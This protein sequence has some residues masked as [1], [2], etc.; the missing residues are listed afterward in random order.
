[1]HFIGID[2]SLTGSGVCVVDAGGQIL[3][4]HYIQPKNSRGVRRLDEITRRILDIA[5]QYDG[6]L[7]TVREEYSYGSKGRATFSLGELGGTIDLSLLRAA[8]G[9]ALDF[10]TAVAGDDK[11]AFHAHFKI[12]PTTHKKL[13]LG[14]GN[15]AKDTAYLLTVAR[16]TGL[17]FERDDIADAYMLARTLWTML[18][19]A[20]GT[21]GSDALSAVARQAFFSDSYRK[22]NAITEAGIRKLSDGDLAQHVA[23]AMQESLIFSQERK[24]HG[25][26]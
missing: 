3:A 17:E 19:V 26:L 9:P 21:L 24:A 1:M 14:K 15:V 18:G 5:A 20:R 10:A 4:K 13:C 22:A 25:H 23:R 11:T 2:Q 8:C 16:H 12:A 7:F 6:P